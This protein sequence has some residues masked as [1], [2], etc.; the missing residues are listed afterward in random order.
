MWSRSVAWLEIPQ[1]EILFKAWP[2]WSGRASPAFKA[3]L[4]LFGT[5]LPVSA[6]Q[7]LTKPVMGTVT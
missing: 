3:A 6:R 7:E 4:L 1:P 5:L 2:A